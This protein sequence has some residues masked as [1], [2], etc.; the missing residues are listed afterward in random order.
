VKKTIFRFFI[1]IFSFSFFS[2]G[3]GMEDSQQNEVETLKAEIISLKKLLELRKGM[4]EDT[5]EVE[6]LRREVLVMRLKEKAKEKKK[7]CLCHE[8]YPEAGEIVTRVLPLLSKKAFAY[9]LVKKTYEDAQKRRGIEYLRDLFSPVAIATFS[10]LAPVS[11]KWKII[12]VTGSVCAGLMNC[13]FIEAG[14]YKKEEKSRKAARDYM[15][16]LGE[17]EQ[18]MKKFLSCYGK[19]AACETPECVAMRE[20][21]DHSGFERFKSLSSYKDLFGEQIQC[22]KR[23]KALPGYQKKK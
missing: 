11:K 12:G 9:S 10:L 1:V 22:F 8:L 14:I 18:Q 15:S 23:L 3:F 4:V 7:S 21:S 17:K 6:E 16:L 2:A 19:I 20:S 5:A 13:C